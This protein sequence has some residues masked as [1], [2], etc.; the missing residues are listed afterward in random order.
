[1]KS[2]G[3]NCAYYYNDWFGL[4]WR[5]AAAYLAA[6]NLFGDQASSHAARLARFAID[7]MKAAIDRKLSDQVNAIIHNA[8]FQ[9]LESA[10]RGLNYLVMN[11]DTGTDLKIRVLNI[12]KDETRKMLRQ[13]RDAAAGVRRP[14]GLDCGHIYVSH[15]DIFWLVCYV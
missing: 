5:Y 6:T 13:Y 9:Q 8:E 7:A 1:L 15:V 12:S 4:T 14:P 2:F 10:W 3:L 11:T